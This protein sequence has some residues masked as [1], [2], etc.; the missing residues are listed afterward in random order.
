MAKSAKT[1]SAGEKLTESDRQKSSVQSLAKGLRVL[2]AF[3]GDDEALTIT[4]I[5]ERADLDPGTTFRMLNTLVDLGYVHRLEKR[6]YAISLKVLDL[7]F[8]AIGRRDLRSVVRPVLRSLVGGKIEAASF[9]VLDGGNVVYV[10]RVRAGLTRLGVDIRIGSG[11]PAAINVLG[12]AILAFL[13]AT[14]LD[15]VLASDATQSGYPVVSRARLLPQLDSIRRNGFA[16]SASQI[17]AGLDVLAVP[18]CDEGGYPI[19]A[20]SVAA[21]SVVC[22]LAEMQELVLARLQKAAGD[23]AKVMQMS[24]SSRVG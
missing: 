4:E 15:Q 3:G 10:E 2:E 22:S 20:I 1:L 13:P 16:A 9:G 11:I 12:H 18:V 23:I 19:A 21:P 24:G 8:N 7:G 6:R 17:S 14:D 5:A